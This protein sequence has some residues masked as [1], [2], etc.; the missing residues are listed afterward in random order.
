MFENSLSLEEEIHVYHVSFC[1][2]LTLRDLTCKRRLQVSITEA[3]DEKEQTSGYITPSDSAVTA[4]EG[5]FNL[6]SVSWWKLC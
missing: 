4:V 6:A 2:P 3:H 5:I 1:G